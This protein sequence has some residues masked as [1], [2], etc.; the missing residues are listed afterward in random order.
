MKKYILEVFTGDLPKAG[1]DAN[2]F[3]TIFGEKGETSEIHLAHSKTHSDKF[4]RNNV[5]LQ[6]FVHSE[7]LLLLNINLRWINFQLRKLIWAN[8]MVLK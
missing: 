5:R 8:F 1:T 4:E 3:L 7:F 2:V 6:K